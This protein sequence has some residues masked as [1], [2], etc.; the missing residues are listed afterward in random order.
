VEAVVCLDERHDRRREMV[1]TGEVAKA[2]AAALEG[3]KPEF[4]LVEP[5]GVEGQVVD[6]EATWMGGDPRIDVR[7]TV[8]VEVVEHEVDDLALG[9]GGVEQVEE[10]EEH[11]LG[12]C[13]GDRPYHSTGVDEQPGGKT[14]GAVADILDRSAA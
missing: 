9:Y 12:P 5:A 1:A 8:S 4:D 13:W 11:L 10:G 14:P 7:P 2:Q 6:G 3:A